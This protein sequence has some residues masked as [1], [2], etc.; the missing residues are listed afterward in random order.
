MS[1]SKA[2]FLVVIKGAERQ[3]HMDDQ[4]LSYKRH[5]ALSSKKERSKVLTKTSRSMTG[6]YS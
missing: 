6:N 4:S 2:K 5:Q 1:E 3:E